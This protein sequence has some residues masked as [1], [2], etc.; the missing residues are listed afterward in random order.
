VPEAIIVSTHRVLIGVIP[1]FGRVSAGLAAVPAW[2]ERAN[3]NL[4]GA[5]DDFRVSASRLLVRFPEF[6]VSVR[7]YRA[8]AEDYR[9]S[10]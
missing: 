10:V 9:V 4:S 2:C 5:N 8:S 6:C 7:D 3:F 1:E